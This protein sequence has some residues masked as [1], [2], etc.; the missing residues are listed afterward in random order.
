MTSLNNFKI[1]EN[2][3]HICFE[4]NRIKVE[5]SNRKISGKPPNIWKLS[6][7]LL[8]KCIF[9]EST[10]IISN[11]IIELNVRTETIKFINIIFG[12][13]FTNLHRVI[14]I[15][16]ERRLTI[17]EK[18]LINWTLLNLKLLKDKSQTGRK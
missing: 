10:H 17:K 14:L 5:I 8:N 2:I 16:A 11:W 18:K 13:I 7:S 3:N 15:H 1:F 9:G 12:K 6:N 4:Q